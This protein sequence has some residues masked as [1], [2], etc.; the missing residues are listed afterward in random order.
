[1][2][3]CGNALFPDILKLTL[4][5][6]HLSSEVFPLNGTFW[7]TLYL[8]GKPACYEWAKP[9]LEAK[10]WKNLC[11]ND[12][13]AGFSYPK[14]EVRNDVEQ[15]REA[16]QSVIEICDNMGMRIDLIDADTDFDPQKT[17]FKVLYKEA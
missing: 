14:K 16:L 7:L 3:L 13:F 1:M 15:V 9:A 4:T 6:F 12:D 11:S 5:R 10:G 8:S 17:T 2:V